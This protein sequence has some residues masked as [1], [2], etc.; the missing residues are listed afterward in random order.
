V[1]AIKEAA[2]NTFKRMATWS[3]V[4]PT[5]T[6][7]NRAKVCSFALGRARKRRRAQT[8]SVGVEKHFPAE[9]DTGDSDNGGSADGVA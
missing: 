2:I 5:P 7:T 1:N 8:G 6:L 3:S 9:S 4:E